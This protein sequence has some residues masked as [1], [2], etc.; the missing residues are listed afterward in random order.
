M[1]FQPAPFAGVLQ[2]GAVLRGRALVAEQE[3]TVEFL[4]V[5]RGPPE[6]VR[7]RARALAN[8]GLLFQDR[9]KGDRRSISKYKSHVFQ[10]LV[11]GTARPILSCQFGTMFTDPAVP[12]CL[13]TRRRPIVDQ[14]KS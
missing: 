11:N 3:G 2:A 4:D 8:G 9:R 6:L 1:N 7:R 13:Q 10:C 12:H 5:D 14:R